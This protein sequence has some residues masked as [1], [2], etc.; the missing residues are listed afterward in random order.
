MITHPHDIFNSDELIGAQFYS[1]PIPTYIATSIAI[2]A[3]DSWGHRKIHGL[4]WSAVLGDITGVA[5]KN[6]GGPHGQLKT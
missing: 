4:S 6:V 1:A 5:E 2:N 3:C